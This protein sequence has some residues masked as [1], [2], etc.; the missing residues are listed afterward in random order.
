MMTRKYCKKVVFVSGAIILITAI[1]AICFPYFTPQ[2]IIEKADLIVVFPGGPGRKQAGYQLV[3]QGYA[4]HIA[5]TS[6]IDK[7]EKWSPKGNA[8]QAFLKQVT[9]GHAR[10]TFEDALFARELVGKDG[11][12]SIILVT[13]DYH[14]LRALFLLRAVLADQRVIV[15]TYGVPL[16]IERAKQDK[17]QTTQSKM[18]FNERI[19]F[20]GSLIEM[21]VYRTTG[22]LINDYAGVQQV[23]NAIKE[24]VLFDAGR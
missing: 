1:Y 15:H 17:R 3:E 10:S 4:D 19:K 8:D 5:I 6:D 18:L 21:S 20:L 16:A 2:N 23:K 13:A 22:L 9:Y 7:Y 24:V 11:L 14:L 12:K